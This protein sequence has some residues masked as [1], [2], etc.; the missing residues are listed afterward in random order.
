[1]SSSR[2]WIPGAILH[3]EPLEIQQLVRLRHEPFHPDLARPLQR[4]VRHVGADRQHRH[5]GS[6]HPP[7]PLTTT[8]LLVL[9]A[10]VRAVPLPACPVQGQDLLGGF[11]PVHG[12]HPQIHQHDVDRPFAAR[13]TING[14]LP[15]GLP[16]IVGLVD[17][18][19]AE[20]GE[21]A[22]EELAVDFV[23]FGHEEGQGVFLRQV[24]VEG[25][26]FL[27]GCPPAWGTVRLLG[28]AVAAR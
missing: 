28:E 11:V 8:A 6:H 2:R 16:A 12:R 19:V 27:R 22:D 14:H 1:M 21:H 3:N 9:I 4:R 17:V 25:V 10:A 13:P 18:G 24:A 5:P 26:D 7:R 20:F 23:V 15:D